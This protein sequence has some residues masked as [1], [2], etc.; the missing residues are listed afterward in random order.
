MP[1]LKAFAAELG[2][3]KLSYPAHAAPASG[4]QPVSS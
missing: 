3:S 4:G 1:L 2:L